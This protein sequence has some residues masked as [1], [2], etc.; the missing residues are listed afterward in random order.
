M[1]LTI[2][3]ENLNPA[4]P[5]TVPSDSAISDALLD[6]SENKDVLNDDQCHVRLR[7]RSENFA[8]LHD[9]CVHAGFCE[10]YANHLLELKDNCLI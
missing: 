1:A 7:S 5:L 4:G 9:H 6:F 3:K 10:S 8:L 2:G